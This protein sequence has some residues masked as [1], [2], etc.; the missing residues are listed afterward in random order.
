MKSKASGNN[1]PDVE[2]IGKAV[3]T[4]EAPA[5]IKSASPVG[6]DH[7]DVLPSE[8]VSVIANNRILFL[9][10]GLTGI[11]VFKQNENKEV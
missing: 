2:T 9:G 3:A 5:S 6:A 1:T 10:Q 7:F 8:T 4:S 11:T